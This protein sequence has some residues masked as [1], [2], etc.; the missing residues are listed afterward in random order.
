MNLVAHMCSMIYEI[1]KE[2]DISESDIEAGGNCIVR[3]SD[4]RDTCKLAD[5]AI[6][7]IKSTGEIRKANG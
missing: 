7:Y 6:D 3:S 2:K 1:C 4:I 5:N